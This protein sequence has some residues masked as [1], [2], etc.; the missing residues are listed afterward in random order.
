MVT[1]SDTTGGTNFIVAGKTDPFACKGFT[2]L[3]GTTI[4]EDQARYFYVDQFIYFGVMVTWYN[5]WSYL[6]V[7]SSFYANY[8]SECLMPTPHVPVTPIW[9]LSRE[10]SIYVNVF[11]ISLSY[12]FFP[13]F[14]PYFC[15]KINP[16][17]ISGQ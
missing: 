2:E 5:W 16:S 3:L 1:V 7:S 17:I 8:P 9:R 13:M 6:K 11:L 12:S 10:S 4:W 14:L 15:S